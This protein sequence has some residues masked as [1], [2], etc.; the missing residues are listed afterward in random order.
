MQG[1][2]LIKFFLILLTLVCLLQL[3]Y[4]IPTNKVEK[5][6]TNYAEQMVSGMSEEE[7]KAKAPEFERNYLDSMTNVG[8]FK[9]PGIVDYT[10]S[11]LK[12]Q[13]LALG[14][15][16]KGGMSAV[17]EVD[18]EE[19]LVNIAGR[20]S[21]DTK[22]QTAL[23]N[24]KEAQKNSQTDF[25]TLFG[26][27]FQ[28]VAEGKSLAS[29][30]SKSDL[31]QDVNL[32]S[33]D[34]D[35]IQKLREEGDQVVGLT[36]KM[37]KERIDKLGVAQ[38]NVSLDEGRDLI[39]VELP[40]IKNEARAMQ[41][42]QSTAK[43]EFWHAKRIND[44][45]LYASL[46]EADTRLKDEFGIEDDTTGIDSL[47]MFQNNGPLLS[48]LQLNGADGI[49]AARTVLGVVEKRDKDQVMELLNKPNIRALF[50]RNMKFMY[51]YKP[52]TDQDK[53]A[54]TKYELYA[55]KLTPGTDKAPLEGDVITDASQSMDPNTGEAEV[56]LVMNKKGA[57]TWGKMTEVA[58][59][60][61]TQ[62]NQREIAIS[63]D[64]QIVT[65]PSL[66]NGAIQGGISS[67]SGDFS[68]QEAVDL[69]NILEVGKLPAKP[70]VIQ[71]SVVGPSLGKANIQ[72]SYRSLLIGF[73]LVLLFMILYYSTGGVISIIA[74]LANL[75]FIFGALSSF[76]TVLTLPGI[77]GIVLTIGMAV[78]AN[79]IIYER[80]REELR[81]GKTML[82]SIADG[83]K[84][85]YSAI[86]DANVTTLLTAFVLS[87]YG[88]GP[89]KGFAVVLI[90]GVLCSLLT[91][92][93]FGRMLIDWWTGRGG[94]IA[95]SNS[96][97]DT[98]FSNIKFNWIGK[99]KVAY[100]ISGIVFLTCLGSILFRG[101]DLG[102]DFKGGYSY[103]VQFAE[104]DNVNIED[105]RTALST[106][107]DG[108]PVIKAVSTE[109]TYN[110]TTSHMIDSVDETAD[111][112]V[113]ETLYNGI[114]SLIP[115]VSNVDELL[116]SDSGDARTHITSSAKVGPTIADDIKKSSYYAGAFALLLIFIYILLR[117]NKWQFSL[118]AVTALFHDSIIVL[119][120]FSIFKGILPWSL[121]IDQ[122]II[123]ALLTVIGYSINDTVVVFD[124]IREYLGIYTNKDKDEV[125]N[126]AISSTF[127]RTLITSL[128]TLIV[129]LILF[130]FGGSSIK[131]FAFALLIGIL[132]GTYSSIFVAS[133]I[134]RDFSGNL[135]GRRSDS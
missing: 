130:I 134:V 64:D 10:Y 135:T 73:G 19:M 43:L 69:A 117:F 34:A 92:V 26:N 98:V 52:Y 23:K 36:Y 17:L 88:L 65:A 85:S 54:T 93:L 84:N 61:D 125:M 47:N 80:I 27:E 126:L 83:F 131:G 14:L 21:K 129:V 32:S 107:F 78:D 38:P 103:N 49:A 66:L 119:G 110:I 122:A 48:K 118:G 68:V 40:G 95:F 123:A 39:L 59:K 57:K 97:S 1:K 114:K 46:I 133:P 50:P 96:F 2:G 102:V 33:S 9:I 3:A 120:I 7:A 101:F 115:S 79:V 112:Q 28:K 91:A 111:R 70:R 108:N 63:L 4:F 37:L 121:E 81:S 11:D 44:D 76:G 8:I 20:G 94:K 45:N 29:I 104:S 55:V 100:V 41:F 128:T 113:V 62:G 42:L 86:I 53:N 127:S 72:K 25:I 60:G 13:Q 74:L 56:R 5:D 89:I 12:A 18:L 132:V 6:A 90:I 16:L 67:I 58:Y 24:A 15:D 82:D 109:N 124:R 35:V 75:F 71:S 22:F 31:L 116:D 99:R 105:V 30:F 87:Y 106:A 77:A 51:S